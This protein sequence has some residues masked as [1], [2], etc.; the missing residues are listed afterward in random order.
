[1][2]IRLTVLAVA[3]VAAFL[4]SASPLAAIT[5][6]ERNATLETHVTLQQAALCDGSVRLAPGTYR[7]VVVSMGDGSVRASFFDRTGR[8]NGEAN[9]IVIVNS[10]PAGGSKV[11]PGG[12]TF[13]ALGLDANSPVSFRT[14]GS[15]LK[16]ALGGQGR[17]QILIG[18]LLPAINKGN[19]QIQGVEKAREAAASPAK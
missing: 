9:G 5:M 8:K 3:L 6:V 2:K 16:L 4:S 14:E 12:A 7:V 18:L 19:V 15:Q 13:P 1:M 11:A 10:R 17:N